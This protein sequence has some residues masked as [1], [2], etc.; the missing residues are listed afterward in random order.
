MGPYSEPRQRN[1]KEQP[2]TPKKC[3]DVIGN[4]RQAGS[5]IKVTDD[6]HTLM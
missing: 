2:A 6:I 1:T 3:H 5:K 4:S